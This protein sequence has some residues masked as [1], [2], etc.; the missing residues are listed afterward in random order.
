MCYVPKPSIPNIPK[1]FWEI[2]VTRKKKVRI[3]QWQDGRWLATDMVVQGFDDNY[4]WGWVAEK[5]ST[6]A[7][8]LN[9]ITNVIDLG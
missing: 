2:L 6:Q 5:N 8:A 4:V 3:C 1:Q 7:I 9:S